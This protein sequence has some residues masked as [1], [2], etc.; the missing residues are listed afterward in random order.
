MDES[1]QNISK[2]LKKK[3]KEQTKV[4]G[5]LFLSNEHQKINSFKQFHKHIFGGLFYVN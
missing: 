4:C 3:K 1:T 5:R 2:E